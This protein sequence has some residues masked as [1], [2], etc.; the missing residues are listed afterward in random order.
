M[1]K[2]KAE[3]HVSNQALDTLGSKEKKKKQENIHCVHCARISFATD[4]DRP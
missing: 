1:D 2:E 4:C 3:A